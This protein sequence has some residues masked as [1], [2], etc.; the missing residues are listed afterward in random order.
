MKTKLIKSYGK[1][2]KLIIAVLLMSSIKSL[3]GSI[4]N[5]NVKDNIKIISMNEEMRDEGTTEEDSYKK[6]LG[7]NC[8]QPKDIK[9]FTLQ[10]VNECKRDDFIR[11]KKKTTVDIFQL[12]PIMEVE[13]YSCELRRTKK[14]EQC[15][16]HSHKTSF[17]KHDL[18]NAV[19]SISP[20]KCRDIVNTCKYEFQ[21]KD[22]CKERN[23]QDRLHSYKL[24]TNDNINYIS[25]F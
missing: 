16:M 7:F 11:K 1:K 3:N 14:V 12:N 22:V 5:N 19:I 20:E 23:N 15:G 2:Y 18:T 25:Y 17:R 10:N 21:N 13:G 6:L 9:P 4:L 8:N 24:D